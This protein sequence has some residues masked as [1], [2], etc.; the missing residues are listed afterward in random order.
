MPAIY[1][2]FLSVTSAETDELGHASNLAYVRWMQDAAVAHSAAQGW[3]GEAYQALGAGFVVRS[4]QIEYLRPAWP[5]DQIVVRTW[6]ANLKRVTSLRRYDIV[7]PADAKLLAR[8]AT[9]W[10]FIKF[11][12]GLPA[13][14]PPEI[15]EAFELVEL[16]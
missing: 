11:A 16:P 4:H 15:A 3:P 13:R 12:T 6:V 1:E 2:H 14:I 5:G 8:A 10:A 9:D 7:R